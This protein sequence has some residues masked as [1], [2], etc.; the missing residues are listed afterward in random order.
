VKGREGLE[1]AAKNR[2][3]GEERG[4]RE[5]GLQIFNCNVSPEFQQRGGDGG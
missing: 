1:G 4:Q 3:E 2:K 5:K